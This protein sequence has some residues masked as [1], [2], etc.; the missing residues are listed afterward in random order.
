MSCNHDCDQGRRCDCRTQGFLT[1]AEILGALKEV[2]PHTQR[3][4]MGHRLF[5]KAIEKLVTHATVK[6]IL[7]HADVVLDSD[8]A[9]NEYRQRQ[10]IR[11]AFERDDQ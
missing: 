11:E 8:L 7:P 3:L 10:E 6:R 9:W 5:A 1:D 4:P 2:D